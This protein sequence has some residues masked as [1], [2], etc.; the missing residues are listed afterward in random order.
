LRFLVI[1]GTVRVAIQL[2]RDLLYALDRGRATLLIHVMWLA[3]LTP[4]LAI[5]ATH[6]GI[7]GVGIAH[8]LVAI[9]IPVPGLLYALHRAGYSVKAM[10]VHLPRP[11]AGAAVA[12]LA[13]Y[14]ASS[15][16]HGDFTRLVVGS[17]AALAVEVA[18]AGP[19]LWRLARS[20]Q[21]VD[22]DVPFHDPTAPEEEQAPL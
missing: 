22:V 19:V 16:V 4:A 5:G 20:Q 9:T 21:D 15:L 14:L 18:V 11:L 6:D 2:G 12:G 8:M 1:V 17:A 3:V 7:R 10:L 13:A